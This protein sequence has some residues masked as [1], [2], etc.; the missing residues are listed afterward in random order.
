M[1]FSRKYRAL[2]F[3]QCVLFAMAV[4]GAYVHQATATHGYCT[5]H[6]ELVHLDAASRVLETTPF[7][8][9]KRSVIVEGAHDCAIMAFGIQA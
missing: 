8:N 4:V 1:R 2:A 5:E 9:V 6:G 3:G 7:S